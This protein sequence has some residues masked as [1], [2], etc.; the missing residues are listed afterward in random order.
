MTFDRLIEILEVDGC[1]LIRRDWED[2]ET[3]QLYDLYEQDEAEKVK[4]L[5]NNSPLYPS[6][7]RWNPATREL[8]L[9]NEPS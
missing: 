8:N 5:L 2:E 7:V 4:I 6:M 3:F 9:T 1:R